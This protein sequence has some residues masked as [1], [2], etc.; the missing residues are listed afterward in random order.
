MAHRKVE[1]AVPKR[2]VKPILNKERGR[3]ME[4][5]TFLPLSFCLILLEIG[6]MR[7]S[8]SF[9]FINPK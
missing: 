6:L 3:N 8:P 4:L 1:G 9:Y 5:T 7:Q 2:V